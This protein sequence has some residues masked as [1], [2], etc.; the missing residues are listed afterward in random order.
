MVGLVLICVHSRGWVAPHPY[1]EVNTGVPRVKVAAAEDSNPS[2]KGA[3]GR[4]SR[5]ILVAWFT[6]ITGAGSAVVLLQST[7][8]GRGSGL[9]MRLARKYGSNTAFNLTVL[10]AL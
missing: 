2:L 6:T 4:G 9:G 8:A 10:Y 7:K 5:S 3:G 1:Q